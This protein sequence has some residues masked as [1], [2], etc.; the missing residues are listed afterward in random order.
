MANN[1]INRMK[2]LNELLAKA[3]D[4][5]Y[6]TGVEIMSDKQ[7]DDLYDE[8]AALEKKTGVILSGSRT[9]Q[10]G[11]EVSSGLK[12]I[13]H[14]SKMLSLDKTK[15]VEELK[16]WLGEH[17]GF[18]SWKLDGLTLVLTYEGGELVQAVT[19]GN[20]EIGEEITANCI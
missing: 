18:L 4:A 2:E 8:L 15:S 12:K 16:S 20:G 19:R 5:Y 14:P 17:K 9:Q 7:Y 13:R 11:F 3:A 1:D 10:V 6:N